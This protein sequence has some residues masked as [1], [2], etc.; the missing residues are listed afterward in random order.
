M[1]LQLGKFDYQNRPKDLIS[2]K[3]TL[4]NYNWEGYSFCTTSLEEPFVP[5]GKGMNFGINQ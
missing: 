1:R 5:H 4:S 3:E 2:T